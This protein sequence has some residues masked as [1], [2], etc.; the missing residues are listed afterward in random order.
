MLIL[1]LQRKREQR[2]IAE[3][4]RDARN[5]VEAVT[6]T[7]GSQ[8]LL[9]A[10]AKTEARL[11]ELIANQTPENYRELLDKSQVRARLN[12]IDF[13]VAAMLATDDRQDLYNFHHAIGLQLVL[14]ATTKTCEISIGTNTGWLPDS[15]GS[16]PVNSD[17]VRGGT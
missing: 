6:R 7:G 9:D 16:H 4:Q 13:D 2:E 1:N 17:R 11:M 8:V 3:T 10:L 14:N 5:L 15:A 12:R